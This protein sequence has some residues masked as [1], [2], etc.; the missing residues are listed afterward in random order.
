MKRRIDELRARVKSAEREGRSRAGPGMDG[1]IRTLEKEVR[2]E[3]RRIQHGRCC[4]LNEIGP[5]S[6][7]K[8]PG[9]EQLLGLSGLEWHW[10]KN[11]AG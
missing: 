6:R 5:G 8:M 7:E 10:K 9:I 1:G 2:R 3:R 4:T 11:S